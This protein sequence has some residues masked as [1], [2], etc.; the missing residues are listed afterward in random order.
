MRGPI[1]LKKLKNLNS[2]DRHKKEIIINIEQ[3][4]TRVAILEMVNLIISISS[5]KKIIELLEVSS[6]VKF[7]T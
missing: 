2:T 4:E 3:L 1:M 6:K 5:E 7:K